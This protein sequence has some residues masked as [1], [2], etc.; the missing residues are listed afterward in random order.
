[1][2]GAEIVGVLEKHYKK[3]ISPHAMPV[4]QLVKYVLIGDLI[5]L[6]FYAVEETREA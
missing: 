6:G 4:T 3:I 1:M 5:L 2:Y